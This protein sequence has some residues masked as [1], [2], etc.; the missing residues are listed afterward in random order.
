M[1]TEA[2]NGAPISG[3]GKKG[4]NGAAAESA[5]P[6]LVNGTQIKEFRTE[7]AKSGGSACGICE[8]KIPKGAVRIGKK[9]Y[10]SVRAKMYGPYDR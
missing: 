4:K 1:L 10:D 3:K 9:E 5:G 8:A 6:A 2:L 7:Y